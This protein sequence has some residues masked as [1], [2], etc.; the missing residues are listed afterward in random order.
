MFVRGFIRLPPESAEYHVIYHPLTHLTDSTESYRQ[1][2]DLI[3]NNKEDV[4]YL[5][6]N[7]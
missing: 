6:I 4:E 1:S 7:V 5:M 2:V 3:L